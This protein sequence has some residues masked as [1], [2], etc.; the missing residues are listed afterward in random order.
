MAEA[1]NT[2][3]LHSPCI[4]VEVIALYSHNGEN[5]AVEVVLGSNPR[6]LEEWCYGYRH[7]ILGK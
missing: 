7:S 5:T 3:F 6:S 2:H 1:K 4:P